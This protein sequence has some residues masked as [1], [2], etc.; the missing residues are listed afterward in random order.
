MKN[1]SMFSALLFAASIFIISCSDDTTEL[2]W[3]NGE[4]S[5]GAINDIVWADEDAIWENDE[6]YDIG[7]KTDSKEVDELTGDVECTINEGG[8]FVT[9]SVVIEETQSSSLTID[10]GSSNVYTINADVAKK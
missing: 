6:G 7:D 3:I 2:G 4:G 10:E 1:L 9:A 5:T 8:D